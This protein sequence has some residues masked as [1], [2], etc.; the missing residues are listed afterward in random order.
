MLLALL[1]SGVDGTNVLTVDI[2][3]DDADVFELL[4]FGIDGT[5]VFELLIL[6]LAKRVKVAGHDGLVVVGAD[7]HGAETVHL[8]AVGRFITLASRTGLALSLSA[9]LTL[10]WLACW[11]NREIHSELVF[12]AQHK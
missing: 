10:L 4:I 8:T 2:G 9:S 1:L 3:V 12:C 5:N 6:D 11:H 7:G